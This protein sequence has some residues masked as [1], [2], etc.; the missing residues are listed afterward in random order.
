MADSKRQAVWRPVAPRKPMKKSRIA[1]VGVVWMLAGVS[2]AC[3]RAVGRPDGVSQ[4]PDTSAF[5]A[6]VR[7][8]VADSSV[9]AADRMAGRNPRISVD[10]RPLSAGDIF[11][12]AVLDS[13]SGDELAARAATLRVLAIPA[14]DSEEPPG[15]GS[16]T[17]P[18]LPGSR[19]TG[20]AAT[21]RVVVAVA[22]P[23]PGDATRPTVAGDSLW[24]A[25]VVL[26]AFG[27]D[28]SST[29]GRDYVLE[30][31]ASGWKV[32]RIKVVGYDF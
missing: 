22:R 27:P 30:R 31:L 9:V 18:T 28:G 26:V 2:W 13:A 20:C 19:R 5:A 32:V 15:C 14:D 17:V 1:T 24:T 4:S 11:T 12:H 16:R 21:W 3:S 23:R 8:V 6:V 29:E 25:R 10:P 7:A